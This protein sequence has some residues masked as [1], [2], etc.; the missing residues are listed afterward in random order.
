[1]NELTKFTNQLAKPE[2]FD[3]IQ[4]GIVRPTGEA[5]VTA[6]LVEAPPRRKGPCA[7]LQFLG[8]FV[9]E[10]VGTIDGPEFHN[11]GVEFYRQLTRNF[12]NGAASAIVVMLLIATLPVMVYQVKQFREEEAR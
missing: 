7:A 11:L 6:R 2:T 4:I 5:T 1:M 9:V 12:N 10:S 3:Q 8:E